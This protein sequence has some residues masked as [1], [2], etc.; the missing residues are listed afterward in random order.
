MTNKLVPNFIPY[1]VRIEKTFMRYGIVFSLL[2]M[3]QGL[4]GGM[5]ISQTPSV[6]EK[7]R[8]NQIF[9]I[10]TLTAIGFTATKDIETSLVASVL[11]I[12]ILY[13]LRTPEERKQ[14]KNK[15]I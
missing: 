3:Y 12:I 2:V 7:L 6:L 5:A 13:L 11:F 14:M 8:E 4:F 15:I 10:I 1:G 9:K